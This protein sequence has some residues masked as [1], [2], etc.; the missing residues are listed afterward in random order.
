MYLRKVK[1]GASMKQKP[2]MTLS[3][4]VIV[5][6]TASPKFNRQKIKT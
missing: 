2:T 6:A 1:G 4:L 3:N 5:K